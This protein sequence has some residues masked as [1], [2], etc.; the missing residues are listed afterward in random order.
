MTDVNIWSAPLDEERVNRWMTCEEEDG[1]QENKIVDW[2][3][4]TWDLESIQLKTVNKSSVCFRKERRAAWFPFTSFDKQKNFFEAADF[5]NLLGGKMSVPRDLTSMEEMKVDC[6]DQYPFTGWM[7]K[8]DSRVFE[9]PYTGETIGPE[10]ELWNSNQPDNNGGSEHC[11]EIE[12]GMRDVSC[13][14]LRSCLLCNFTRNPQFELRGSCP[15]M[16]T[17]LLD[18]RYSLLLDEPSEGRYKI[19][20]WKF[21]KLEWNQQNQRWQLER[22]DEKRLIAFCNETSDYPLGHNRLYNIVAD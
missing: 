11:T 8:G 2:T 19:L 3:T 16:D 14:G 13:E 22:R 20:G 1:L 21:T 15:D 4:S 12:N 17:S 5:C 10:S 7:E 6:G 9:D 18:V